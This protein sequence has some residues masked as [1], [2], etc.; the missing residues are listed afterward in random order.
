M[1]WLKGLSVVIVLVLSGRGRGAGL[2]SAMELQVTPI[3][4]GSDKVVGSCRGVVVVCG[5]VYGDSDCG[6]VVGSGD[7]GQ[8][9]HYCQQVARKIVIRWI[10]FY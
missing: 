8:S 3:V 6:G 7:Q 2:S 9:K 5:G 1:G 10:Y 4:A